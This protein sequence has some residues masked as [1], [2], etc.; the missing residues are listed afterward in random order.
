MCVGGWGGGAAKSGADL[1]KCLNVAAAAV[2]AAGLY[3][4]AESLP[5]DAAANRNAA[6]KRWLLVAA[7]R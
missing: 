6:A 1:V 3:S 7:G 2:A 5:A 4:I